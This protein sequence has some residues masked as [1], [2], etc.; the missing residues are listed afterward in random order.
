MPMIGLCDAQA[1]MDT[2]AAVFDRLLATGFASEQ[3]RC[4]GASGRHSSH[5]S[6]RF[7][8]AA[9]SSEVADDAWSDAAELKGIW[10]RPSA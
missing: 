10:A 5:S 3:A 2:R 1:E 7:S 4:S 9:G 8:A 6:D